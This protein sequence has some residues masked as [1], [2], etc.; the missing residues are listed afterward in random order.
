MSVKPKK[1]DVTAQFRAPFQI[2]DIKLT[3]KQRDL[4]RLFKN[5]NCKVVFVKG[6]AG[7]SKTFISVFA[8]LLQVREGRY[9]KLK[10]L[11]A[12]VE[13]SQSKLGFLPGDLDSKISP[14]CIALHDKLE[15]LL[16]DSDIRK[17][18]EDNT[19]QEMP[20]NFLRG[21]TFKDSFIIIDEAQELNKKDLIT[22]LSR[23]G[24]GTTLAF[25]YDPHQSDIR[26]SGIEEIVSI[27]DDQEA[28]DKGIYTFGFTKEDI[29][30]SEILKFIM[31]RLEA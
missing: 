21:V 17:L 24:E 7:T 26:N 30:R 11:R 16:D 20:V 23:I 25:C 5:E 3:D 15:E 10:Y 29:M 12:A 19:V 18:V 4:V 2:K 22:I 27:F 14:F 6:C 8:G 1:K 28:Y 13:S 9:G 31:G